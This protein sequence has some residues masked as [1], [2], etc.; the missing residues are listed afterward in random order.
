MTRNLLSKI[1]SA[2][3]AILLAVPASFAQTREISGTIVDE[4]GTP[5]IGA[6]VFVSEIPELGAVSDENGNFVL[7]LTSEQASKASTLNVSCLGMKSLT[8]QIPLGGVK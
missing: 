2:A 3:V 6:A 1:V 7:A 8:V 4:S 5:V